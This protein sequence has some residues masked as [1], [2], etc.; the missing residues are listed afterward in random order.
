MK[1]DDPDARAEVKN[2][3]RVAIQRLTAG[4]SAML[5]SCPTRPEGLVAQPLESGTRTHYVAEAPIVSRRSTSR[6]E[7]GG[8]A[9][10]AATG[11]PPGAHAQGG[12]ER[13]PATN[14]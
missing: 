7:P 6:S 14:R 8:A 5:A 12:G 3:V 2:V 1:G 10:A 4:E 13:G 11:V 9:R